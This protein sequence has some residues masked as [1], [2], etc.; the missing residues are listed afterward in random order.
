MFN[1]MINMSNIYIY[2]SNY[3]TWIISSRKKKKPKHYN[4]SSLQYSLILLK[5]GKSHLKKKLTILRSCTPLLLTKSQN[6][7]LGSDSL[8]STQP[9]K[10]PWADPCGYLFI[11]FFFA[12]KNLNVIHYITKKQARYWLIK[13]KICYISCEYQKYSTMLDDKKF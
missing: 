3:Y 2:I 7:L 10:I 11:F 8:L 9:R 4:G 6:L 13:G 5:K 12:F 1:F